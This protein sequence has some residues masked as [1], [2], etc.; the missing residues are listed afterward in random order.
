MSTGCKSY[1]KTLAKGLVIMYLLLAG[2]IFFDVVGVEL[3]QRYQVYLC[4][5]GTAAVSSYHS[6]ISEKASK[7]DELKRKKKDE[8]D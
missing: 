1:L 4:L 6:L 3:L 5:L 2:M 7:Y 8:A